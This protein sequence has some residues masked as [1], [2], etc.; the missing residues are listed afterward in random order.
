MTD[1]PV[2]ITVTGGAGAIGYSLL[3]RI[4]SGEMLGSDVPVQL[5]VLEV[6]QALDKLKGVAMELADCAYPLLEGVVTTADPAEAFDG[7]Q[8]ALLVGSKPRGQGETRGDLLKANAAIFAS[9]GRALAAHASA[10][11]RVTVTGNPAN[12]NALTVSAVAEG[13]DPRH[14]TA[15]TRLDH[16]RAV[17]QLAA[18]SG[19]TAGEVRRMIIWGNHSD[20]QVPDLSH[21][22]VSGRPAAELVDADW[23][24][25]TFQPTVA[26]RGASIIAAR[27]ASSAA[28]AA[29]ATL[30]H[31]R[32]WMR[33]TGDDWVSMA[34]VSDGSYD[35]PAGLV[36]SFPVR[37]S[38]GEWEIVQGLELDDATR[39]AIRASADELVAERAA[40][41]ELGLL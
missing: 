40:V 15:L 5:R 25:D 4:A 9:Q 28:S 3:F 24:R 35:V 21:A 6:P 27:G 12:T 41:Q 19:V 18:R 20:T 26:S 29:N 2:R 30:S 17:A 32:D 16:D 34:V 14:I 36:S 11:V 8:H 31:V 7:A 33:G 38:N 10:D 1:S 13:I 39:E 37:C 23:I 22:L